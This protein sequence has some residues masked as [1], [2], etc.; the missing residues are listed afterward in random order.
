[1]RAAVATGLLVVA[2]TVSAFFWLRSHGLFEAQGPSLQPAPFRERPFNRRLWRATDPYV[3]GGPYNRR[4]TMLDD[5][6]RRIRP[7]M[8]L[9]KATSLLGVPDQRHGHTAYWL[10]GR[11]HALDESC[12]GIELGEAG[13]IGRVVVI[14]MTHEPGLPH[15]QIDDVCAHGVALR[16]ASG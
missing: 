3:P 9:R 7:R 12:L 4:G 1:M 16:R 6:V 10:T 2:L 15:G 14:D 13:R 11:W 8:P 5:L